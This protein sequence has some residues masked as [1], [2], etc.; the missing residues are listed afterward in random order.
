MLLFLALGAPIV[1]IGA[2]DNAETN[3]FQVVDVLESDGKVFV[4]QEAN[5]ADD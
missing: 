3:L 1:R 4:L 5:L 2:R